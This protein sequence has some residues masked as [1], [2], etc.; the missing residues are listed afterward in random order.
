MKDGGSQGLNEA[1]KPHPD[2]TSKKP[3]NH[4]LLPHSGGA[5][6]GCQHCGLVL[7]T[8]DLGAGLLTSQPDLAVAL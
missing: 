8:V 1:E 5:I 3:G 7:K 6:L 2:G 4:N